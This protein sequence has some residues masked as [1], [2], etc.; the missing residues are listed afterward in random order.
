MAGPSRP[1][2]TKTPD[3]AVQTLK[4]H[5]EI[6]LTASA[7]SN[8]NPSTSEI[9]PDKPKPGNIYAWIHF[10]HMSFMECYYTFNYKDHWDSGCITGYTNVTH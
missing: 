9:D 2:P 1:A 7:P 6:I 8:A 4:N 10:I 3:L 5:L